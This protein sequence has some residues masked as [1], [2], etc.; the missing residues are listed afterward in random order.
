[1]T[2]EAPVRLAALLV[3]LALAVWYLIARSQGRASTIR[4]SQMEAA[5]AASRGTS[6][7]RHTSAVLAFVG[8]SAMVV[9]FARPVM[10]VEVPVD[11]ATMILAIDVSLSMAADDV[12]PT[13][14]AAAQDAA[15]RFLALAPPSLRVGLVAFA[16]NA[17]PVAAPTAD[18]A[19][20]L[21]AT[22]RLG[23]AEGTA[24]GEA[25]FT[26]LDQIALAAPPEGAPAAIVVLSD[27]ETTMG[28]DDAD[29]AE[30]AVAAG[31]PVYTIAFGTPDGEIRYQGQT[32]PVPVNQG[33]LADVAATTGGTFFEAA[34]EA[35]LRGVFDSLESQLAYEQEQRQVTDRFVG[36]A[37][38]AIAIAV[39]LSITWF[40]RSL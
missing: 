1:M 10:A 16:G 13:R 21:D 12:D 7:K 26:S 18:R 3:P 30:A 27:G 34:D 17:L 11:Q 2:F 32:I 31:I 19:Q 24:V 38:V 8:L 29:A 33:A 36:A 23:L 25:V 5:R 15:E 6:W 39:G 14:I 20:V 22:G 28:R 4:F 40:N 37:L 35:E 9:A